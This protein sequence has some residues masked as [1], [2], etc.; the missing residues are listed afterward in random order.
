MI[1]WNLVQHDSD[2]EDDDVTS[3]FEDEP[4]ERC[5]TQGNNLQICQPFIK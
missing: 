4:K 5:S 1:V 3:D 2:I